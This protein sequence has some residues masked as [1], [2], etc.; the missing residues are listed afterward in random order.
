MSEAQSAPASK[1]IFWRILTSPIHFLKAKKVLILGFLLIFLTAVCGFLY[2][3]Y[4]HTAQQLWAVLNP[5]PEAETTQL[6][7]ELSQFMYLPEEQP[8]VATVTDKDS[9]AAQDFFLQAENG[10]KVLIFTNVKK[11]ILYRPSERKIVNVAP[12]I[13][14]ESATPDTPTPSPTVSIPVVLL[15]GSTQVGITNVVDDQLLANFPQL[16]VINKLPAQKND[17]AQTL[18]IDLTGKNEVLVKEIASN[19]KATVTTLPEGETPPTAEILIIVG[20]Q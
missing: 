12:L 7:S 5:N 3:K 8:T 1:S 9:L 4:R 20:N 2:W 17:Y 18:V 13:V 19:L 6:L 15:N 11:V 14:Q 16:S 10:D